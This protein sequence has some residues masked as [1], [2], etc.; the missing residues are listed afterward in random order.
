[1]L[2]QRVKNSLTKRGIHYARSIPTNQGTII[3]AVYKGKSIRMWG[4]N[5]YEALAWALDYAWHFDA[6]LSANTTNPLVP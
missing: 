3:S 4:I 1:M 6:D 2:S 5:E